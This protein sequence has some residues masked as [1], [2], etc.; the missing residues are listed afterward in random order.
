MSRPIPWERF[1]LVYGGAQKNLGP[2][3]LTV[4]FIRKSIVPELNTDI[5]R[6]LQYAVHVDKDSMFNTPPVF[7]VYMLGKVLKW[8][9]ASGGLDAMEQAAARKS[10]MVYE[11][12]DASDGYYRCPVD[13]ACRSH[14]NVVFR[15]PDEELEA[16]FL[17]QATAA[18]FLNLKGHR[19][20][21]GLR[22]SIYNAMPEAGAAEL[23]AFMRDFRERH[24]G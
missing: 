6:Y 10:G 18:R 19:S 20:V 4:V 15:L 8:M 1:D 3:G 5:A 9:K 23:A 17:K 2:A 13:R 21:G 14:M 11:V 16:E 7:P 12:I 22:A 24:P